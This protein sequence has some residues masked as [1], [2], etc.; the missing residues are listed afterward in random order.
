[1]AR[2]ARLGALLGV[3]LLVTAGASRAEEGAAGD[4]TERAALACEGKLDYDG[5]FDRYAKV[6]DRL[7]SE[8]HLKWTQDDATR[9]AALAEVAVEKLQFLAEKTGRWRDLADTLEKARLG[10]G[11]TLGARAGY[12]IARGK[13]AAGDIA[14]AESAA[15]GLGFVTS[16]AICGPFDNERGGGFGHAFEPEKKI[17]LAGRYP[18]K[19]REIGWIVPERRAFLG[20]VDLAAM[21]RPNEETLAYALAYVRF[22]GET[23]WAAIHVGSDEGCKVWWNDDE[24]ISHDVNRTMELDQDAAPVWLLGKGSAA[25]GWNKILVKVAQRKGPWGFMLRVTA[26][27]GSPLPVKLVEADGALLRAGVPT[28]PEKSTVKPADVAQGPIPALAALDKDGKATAEDLFHL[29]YLLYRL[30]AHDENKHP[31]RDAFKK[32]C[33]LEPK[34]AVYHAYLSFVSGQAGEFSVNREE[35]ARRRELERTLALDPGYAR[36]ALILAEYYQRSL[37]EPDKAETFLRRA[38]AAAPDA[39]EAKLL[40]VELERVRGWGGLARAHLAALLETP[41]AQKSPE[42]LRRMAAQLAEEGQV[43]RAKEVLH[44]ALTIDFADEQARRQ[45][46]EI[47]KGRGDTDRALALL[48]ER[49]KLRPFDTDAYLERARLLSG[50]DRFEEAGKELDAALAIAREDDRLVSEEGR[51]AL[52][53][54][55]RERALALFGRALELNPNLVEVRKYVEFLKDTERPFEDEHRLDAEA[56]LADAAKIPLDPEVTARTLLRNVVSKVNLDGTSSEYT[57]EIVRVENQDGIAQYE[58]VGVTYAIG[59]QKATIKRATVVKKDGRREEA[60]IDN[61]APERAQGGEFAQY[62]ERSVELPSVEVGDVIIFEN[63]VDDLKQ[64]FFGDYFG[65]THYFQEFEPI[66]R[67]RYVL[68]APSGRSFYFNPRRLEIAPAKKTSADGSTVTWIWEQTRIPRIQQEPNMPPYDEVAP[69]IQVSTFQDWNA[70]A[71]WYWNLVRKQQEVSDEMRAKVEELTKDAKTRE[72]RIKAIYDFVVTDVRYNGKWEFGIHGFKPYNAATIFTRRFGDC[73]DKA[74][75]IVTML[76]VA[77]VPAYPVLINGESRRGEEDLSLPLMTHFN[78]CIAY[79]PGPAPDGREGWFLDGTAQDH[80]ATNLPNMDYGATCLIVKPEGGE[81]TRVKWPDPLAEN[82]LREHHA[83]K[84]KRDGG[85]SVESELDPGGVYSVVT[86]GEFA[87]AG[88]R[89][90]RLE[91][92]YGRSFAGASIVEQKFSDLKDLR[93]PVRVRFRMD[94]PKFVKQTQ[95]GW[96]LE[97]IQSVLFHWLYAD[98]MS[99]F[100]AKSERKFDVV[101]PVPS[102][103]D[104]TIEYALPEGYSLKHAPADVKLDTEFGTYTKTYEVKGNLLR[105]TRKL[106]VKVQRVPVEKY[107]AWRDFTTAIDR[108]DDEKATLGKG[109]MEE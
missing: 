88:E 80:E 98:K 29:G 68:I 61:Y 42:A 6:L 84:L 32:A 72:E 65:H 89:K 24:V 43:A 19:T 30:H 57:Q 52:R 3:T 2:K 82:G 40:E 105:V 36:A 100:G 21:L 96:Q 75:L 60:R 97:E 66:E 94:V 58:Q 23:Q 55:E 81:I 44:R 31:D 90:E 20:E 15:A 103:V 108:A 47:A 28:L 93:E 76:G 79:V 54:G 8:D 38:L 17:D 4:A 85:A 50:V 7:L 104:E 64:S 18:G 101:L 62:A 39:L 67:S 77:G 74:T 107:Q 22:D 63:R 33:E 26:P 10:L 41:A 53:A 51:V 106:E 69:C 16:W 86:R 27:D 34:D 56:V 95:G 71:R 46:I 99:E 35:N 91:K 9:A 73:K 102:G 78:H 5:A 11:P 70:F 83:V 14:G 87:N 59:E 1:M 37:R 13:L 109:G 48:A 49:S 12:C 45:L 92:V 25:K